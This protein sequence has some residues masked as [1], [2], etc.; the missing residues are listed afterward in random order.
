MNV[1]VFQCREIFVENITFT[2][3]DTKMRFSLTPQPGE[4]GFIQW[5]DAMKMVARLAG[6]IPPEFRKKASIIRKFSLRISYFFQI[7]R[8]H[9]HNCTPLFPKYFTAMAN[10]GRTSSRAARRRLEAG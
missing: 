3:E 2:D 4:S 10:A 9:P 1:K 6:G 8:M 5:L 7:L